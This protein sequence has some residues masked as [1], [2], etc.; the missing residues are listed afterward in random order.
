MKNRIIYISSFILFIFLGSG[1]QAQYQNTSGVKSNAKAKMPKQNPWFVGGMIGGGW[2]SNTAYIELSPMLGYK[3]N[4][5]FHVATRLT[6]IYSSYTEPVL[7][8]KIQSHNYGG[9]LLGRYR[10]LKFLFAQAEYEMLNIKWTIEGDRRFVNSLFIGGGLF[11]SMGG[12]GFATIAILY[13]VLEDEY[14][15][16]SNPLIRI[17]F[18][19]GF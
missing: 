3:V 8:Q 18:G 14:S 12:R 9:S 2:S 17:G 5:D 4:P 11:Q 19:V 10:F 15:P 16:Y 6:Y 7:N 13:N 1:V